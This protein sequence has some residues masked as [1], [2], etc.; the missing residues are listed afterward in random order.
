[1][2]KVMSDSKLGTPFVVTGLLHMVEDE[3]FTPHEAME[4]LENIK[5]ETYFAL[6]DVYKEK[7]GKQS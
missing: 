1:M 5:N 7:R 6:M 3:G 4:I 2:K